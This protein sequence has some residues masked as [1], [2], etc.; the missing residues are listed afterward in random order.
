MKQNTPVWLFDLD[1]TLHDANARIFPRIN[2]AMTEYLAKT[3]HL[4]TA[5]A[6]AL[7]LHYW[8]RYGATL[9]GMQRH[10]GTNPRHFLQATHQFED[11]SRLVVF[12][13]SLPAC[14]RQLPGRKFVFSNA[15]R[16]YIRI[17]LKTT[18]LDRVVNRVFSVED[19][20]Y[21]PKP[22]LRAYLAVLRQLRVNPRQCIM[23]EDS[24]LNLRVA[25]RLGMRTIWLAPSQKQP[26]WVDLR[27]DSARKLLMR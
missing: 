6:D 18:G 4:A 15:P 23:V 25:K 8:Q 9:K 13:R 12:D 2:L 21:H 5:D 11:L 22:Q 16:S 10:H 24:E 3:L 14:L 26:A 20:G 19:L 7:R 27:L 17:V 1:N